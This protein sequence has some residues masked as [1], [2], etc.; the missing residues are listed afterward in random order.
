MFTLSA[1]EL[2]A[3]SALKLSIL[4]VPEFRPSPIEDGLVLLERSH[5]P[6]FRATAEQAVVK[7]LKLI[8]GS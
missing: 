3:L 7:I 5:S 4:A 6:E 8:G 1:D 2:M